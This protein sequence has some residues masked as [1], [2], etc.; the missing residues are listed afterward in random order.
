[1]VRP[2]ELGLVADWFGRLGASSRGWLSFGKVRYGRRGA[3]GQGQ[4]GCCELGYGLAGEVSS[5]KVR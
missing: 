2:V 1:M 4:A 5:G 3:L